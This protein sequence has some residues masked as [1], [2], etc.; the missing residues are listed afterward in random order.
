MGDVFEWLKGDDVALSPE[1]IDHKLREIELTEI[2]GGGGFRN[3]RNSIQR[4]HD[5]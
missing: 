4:K 1:W 5:N 2:G 3:S